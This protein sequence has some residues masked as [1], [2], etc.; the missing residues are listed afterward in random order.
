MAE[1]AGN[2]NNNI[3]PNEDDDG[4]DSNV[5]ALSQFDCVLFSLNGSSITTMFTILTSHA[6]RHSPTCPP[7]M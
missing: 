6:E 5:M 1:M 2:S 4:E 3:D 7:T